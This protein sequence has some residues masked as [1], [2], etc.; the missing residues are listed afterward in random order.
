MLVT[1]SFYSLFAMDKRIIA[2]GGYSK[3]EHTSLLST[4]HS[5]DH[6][7]GLCERMTGVYIICYLSIYYTIRFNYTQVADAYCCLVMREFLV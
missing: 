4:I 3:Y 6:Q 1:Q 5:K 2:I 7:Q